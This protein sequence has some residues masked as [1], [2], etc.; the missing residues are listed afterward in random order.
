MPFR[1]FPAKMNNKL[2][3]QEMFGAPLEEL[4]QDYLV[5]HIDGGA[6]GNPGPAGYGVVIE[7]HAGR[8]IEQLN[9][10]LGTQTNNFAEYSGLLV[11]LEY[12]LGHGFRSLK[13][14]SDSEL[15]VKQIKGEYKVR[16]EAL[17]DIYREA[18]EL[19]A[20]LEK[21]QVRH[22]PREQN[23][24]ADRLANL[25][26]DKGMGRKPA[27]APSSTAV[28]EATGIVTGGVIHFIDGSFPEGAQVIIR[29][30]K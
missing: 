8:R 30:K 5:A 20:R 22:I 21:F 15:L 28:Q 2:R 10:F 25:A 7:D 23:R 19:I 17:L 11:A 14:L 26:M 12:A 13:V 16:S 3:T 29:R 6:R 1:K 27:E 9:G 4:D 24:E 18:K